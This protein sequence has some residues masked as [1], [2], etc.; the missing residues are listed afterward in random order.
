MAHVNRLFWDIEIVPNVGTFWEAGW[1]CRIPWT[2]VTKERQIICIAAQW[3]HGKRIMSWDWGAD[4]DDGQLLKEFAKEAN[5][6]DELVAHNGDKYDKRMFAGRC[7]KHGVIIDPNI[8]QFDT[9]QVAKRR[10]KLNSY[11]LKYIAHYLGLKEGKDEMQ[12]EDWLRCMEGNKTALKKMVKYCRQDITVL[13]QVYERIAPY[14][15]PKTHAGTAMGKDKWSCSHCGSE[16]VVQNKKR[17]TAAGTPQFQFQCKACHSYYTINSKA[18]K[19]Y[20]EAMTA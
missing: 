15:N 11:S 18:Q 10:F 5:K 13:R 17:F 6:A 20:F 14:H 9:F 16:K 19:D 8:K 2:N 3:E 1:R 4:M 12:Y 7:L